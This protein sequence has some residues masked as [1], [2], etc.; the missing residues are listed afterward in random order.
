VKAILDSIVG[1]DYGLQC[2][3]WT[4]IAAILQEVDP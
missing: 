3:E 4:S 1:T 2:A